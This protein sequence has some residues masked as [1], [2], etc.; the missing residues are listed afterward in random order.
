MDKDDLTVWKDLCGDPLVLP[1]KEKE[2]AKPNIPTAAG[3]PWKRGMQRTTTALGFIPVPFETGLETESG[4]LFPHF[5]TKEKPSDFWAAKESQGLWWKCAS[6][7]INLVINYKGA[8]ELCGEGY[9][10][11]WIR[12]PKLTK[13]W[14]YGILS[15]LPSALNEEWKGLS[16]QRPGWWVMGSLSPH[17]QVHPAQIPANPPRYQHPHPEKKNKTLTELQ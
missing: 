2:A 5:H 9:S 16:L 1:K 3:T 15:L 12:W 17:R 4:N 11:V 10:E 8:K 7:A 14:T 13:M 6:S